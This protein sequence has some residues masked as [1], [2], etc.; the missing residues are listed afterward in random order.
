MDLAGFSAGLRCLHW[1][2]VGHFSPTSKGGGS[3]DLRGG[4]TVLRFSRR[5]NRGFGRMGSVDVSP[6]ECMSQ[7]V[8]DDRVH[9]HRVRVPK[10]MRR[11]GGPVGSFLTPSWGPPLAP[12]SWPA[13]A[14]RLAAAAYAVW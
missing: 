2:S 3:G 8:N 13:P 10:R 5:P 9:H 12:L 1:K 6:L 14:Y 7:L 11:R 4:G